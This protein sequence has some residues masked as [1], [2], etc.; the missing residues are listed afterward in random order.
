MKSIIDY[1]LK[2]SFNLGSDLM[3][4]GD[5][6]GGTTDWWMITDI[7]DGIAFHTHRNGASGQSN[8]I[9]LSRSGYRKVK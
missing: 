9:L 1:V 7:R 3:R 4:V 6:F 8:V 5:K 2:P